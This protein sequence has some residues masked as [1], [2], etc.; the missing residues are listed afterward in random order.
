MTVACSQSTFREE[1]IDGVQLEAIEWSE[2]PELE[3]RGIGGVHVVG[4]EQ[5]KFPGFRVE[6]MDGVQVK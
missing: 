4:I 6:K 1:G 2:F 3:R 5:P